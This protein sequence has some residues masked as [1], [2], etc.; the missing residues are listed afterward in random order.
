MAQIALATWFAIATGMFQA[1][2]VPSSGVNT[3]YGKQSS[4]S[5]V[6]NTFTPGTYP[7][8]PSGNGGSFTTTGAAAGGSGDAT[9]GTSTAAPG[10][11]SDPGTTSVDTTGYT[12]DE[13]ESQAVTAYLKSHRLPLVGAQV[14]DNTDGR[15]VIVLYGFVATDFGKSD[16]VAK[17][18]HALGN[19]SVTVDNRIIV[20]PELLASGSSAGVPPNSSSAPKSDNQQ[21]SN[22]SY[23]GVSGYM[24]QQQ[25]QNQMLSQQFPGGSGSALSMVVPM[26]ALLAILGVGM[27][28]G[29][30]SSFG[31]FGM[32]APGTPSLSPFGASPYNPYPGYPSPG[33]SYP[34]PA[35]PPYPSYP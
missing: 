22:Q 3:S 34:S 27:T 26:I 2:V 13:S 14:M 20:R 9:R 21:A 30:T 33:Y 23:P 7:A 24:S 16:A 28:S 25:Q 19:S 11:T 18:R 4:G 5:A 12:K 6:G 10:A 31:G 29:G 8:Y 35:Y 17:A 32:G 1:C 15:R